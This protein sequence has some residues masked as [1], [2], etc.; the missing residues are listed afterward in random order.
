MAHRESPSQ[1]LSPDD[2]KLLSTRKL[3][4]QMMKSSPNDFIE[5]VFYLLHQIES[6][7]PTQLDIRLDKITE[8]WKE[9]GELKG[10][11]RSD[12]EPKE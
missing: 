12:R 1:V 5:Y 2:V 4:R 3:K 6:K 11:R 9:E 7:N 10:R 8:C